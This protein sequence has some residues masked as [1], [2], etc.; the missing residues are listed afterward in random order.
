MFVSYCFGVSCSI[1]AQEE[2]WQYDVY[3][4]VLM[5]YG[6][7]Q[8]LYAAPCLDAQGYIDCIDRNSRETADKQQK[9]PFFLTISA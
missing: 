6:S 1:K 9:K 3:A 5:L 7:C 8:F 2:W 4:R